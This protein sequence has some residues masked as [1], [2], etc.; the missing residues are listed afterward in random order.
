LSVTTETLA[1]FSQLYLQKGQW[2]GKQLLPRAWIEEATSAKIQQPAPSM[3]GSDAD[4][5]KL[6]QTSDWH[7][8]YGYQIWRC[9]HNAFRGDGAFGQFCIVMPDQDAVVAITSNTCDYQGAL[10]LVW[11]YVLPSMHDRALT[12][13]VETETQ[14]K[15]EFA[16]LILPLPTGAA[17]SPAVGK[18]ADKNFRLEPNSLG[19]Q[20]V[21]FS[22]GGESCLFGLKDGKGASEVRC[23]IG[24]WT[25][26]VTNMPG[27]P[28]VITEMIGP[29]VGVRGPVK[30]AAAG[31]WKDNDAFQMVWRYFET[32]HHDTVTC[33][34][35][36]DG[37][38]I[39]FLNSITQ[40]WLPAS[41]HR[42][43]RPV[44]KGRIST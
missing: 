39:E 15:R 21:S 42:E 44:L 37:I 25:D 22:F 9:R 35:D 38:N 12:E 23:G 7:Q 18:I 32:P 4:L 13:D 31:A 5:E 8:G 33:R 14:L 17:T 2:K 3:G 11:E 28:P 26:G 41:W 40:V 16:S 29:K 24:Q 10:N 43:T 34:F 1:K 19:A 30:V 6:K 20:S 27:T 36:G